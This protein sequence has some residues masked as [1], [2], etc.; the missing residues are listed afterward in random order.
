MSLHV[1]H[2]TSDEI[3]ALEQ[4][5]AEQRIAEAEM[6]AVVEQAWNTWTFKLDD[7]RIE[8]P[9]WRI[10]GPRLDRAMGQG[11]RLIAFL[12][13]KRC[14]VCFGH[15]AQWVIAMD[16]IDARNAMFAL[17]NLTTLFVVR[18]ACGTYRFVDPAVDQ[19]E[20]WP[21]WGRRDRG[22]PGDI[23]TGAKFMLKDMRCLT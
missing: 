22:L 11:D 15:Y 4:V 8:G 21:N 1:A 6:A 7:D 10:V 18:F 5:L 2:R 16:K 13:L 9:P 19:W 17:T 3:H 20:E 12:E 14:G 23:E